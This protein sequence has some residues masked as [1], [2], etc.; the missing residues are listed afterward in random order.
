MT[1]ATSAQ[2]KT[3]TYVDGD[4]HEGNVAILGPRSHAMWLGTSVFD[5]ARWFEGVA[6]DL[7]LHSQARQRLG[8]RARPEADH[9][10]RRDRRPDLGRAEEVRRQD[11]GL[12]PADV[13]GRA[14][15]LYGR[16]GRSGIDALLPLPLR[17]ADDRARPAS[18]SPCRRSAGRR[19]RPCRPTPRPAAS[20]PTTAARSSRPRCAASTT[21]WCST[22]WAMSPRPATSN[23]FLVKD[24][25]VL[26]PAANGTFLSGITRARTIALLAEQGIDGRRA[27]AVGP[28]VPGSR[29]DLL[30]RQPLQGRAGHPHRGSPPAAR[31]GR[32]EGARTLL[33]VGA[34]DAASG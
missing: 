5:G 19:W 30:D 17:I 32:Q 4:W 23:I 31:P 11:G 15:R 6:P 18:R 14:W 10:G 16:A 1:L 33:G 20:I 21:R 3:W 34:F 22:C 2:S 9:D 29:R 25:Q 26:T 24:G 12:H 13:L 8:D 27:D 28:R 7:D